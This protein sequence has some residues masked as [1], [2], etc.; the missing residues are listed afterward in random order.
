VTAVDDDLGVAESAGSGLRKKGSP[1]GGAGRLLRWPAFR[2]WFASQVLSSSGSAT[3]TVAQ[4]WL[5][6]QLTGR[7]I[8]LGVLAAVT[9]LPV[10]LGA[11]W[12]GGLVDRVDRRRLLVVTQGL[13]V[14][15]SGSQAVLV[16]S[17]RISPCM[18]YLLGALTGAISAVDLPARQ[19]YVLELVGREQLASAIGLNEVVLNASRVIGPA[20]GGVLLATVGVATCFAVNAASYLPVLVVLARFAPHGTHVPRQP[21]ARGLDGWRQVRNSPAI[22][23]CI[24][25]ALAAAMLFN[26]GIA[27]P[28]L[29]SRVFHLGGGGYGAMMASFGVGALPGAVVAATYG[30][31]PTGQKV[32]VLTAAT[33]V[34]VLATA[35][36]PNTTIACIGIALSGFL[37][38][39]LIAL[40]NTLVQLQA[41]PAVRGRVMG[42]WTMALPGSIPFTGLLTAFV[43]QV[44]GAR[45][46]FSA[47]GVVLVFVAAITW[48]ALKPPRDFVPAH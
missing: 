25:I 22:R 29:A 17:G 34:T 16:A 33:G 7:A 18:I 5:I 30:S 8:D 26:L 44:G 36:A 12:A 19:I 27:V 24:L 10:L 11:G 13:F 2:W 31:R 48:S 23:S 15:V 38:I 46:G 45:A 35:V 32:R 21:K 39:W 37:S 41:A 4:S 40:A 14:L 47:A 43:A 6:Y 28:L 9:W 3:A 1:L 42:I 20:V